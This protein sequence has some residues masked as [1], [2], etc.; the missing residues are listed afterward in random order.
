MAM[1]M[2]AVASS[3][4][5][6][7]A[8]FRDV[9]AADLKRFGAPEATARW[10]F[11]ERL[12]A[13]GERGE[14]GFSAYEG[15]DHLVKFFT[16]HRRA[17][18]PDVFGTAIA[19]LAAASAEADRRVFQRLGLNCDDL[20]VA[21]MARYNAQ[22]YA[23]QRAYAVPERQRIKVL[24][25]FGAGHGRMANLAF[26]TPRPG[27]RV[28]CYIAVDGIPSTYFVQSLYF[29]ALGLSV[30]D[31][32]DHADEG[33]G[34]E[35][36]AAAIQS[37][38][39]VHLPTWCLSLIPDGTADL[40]SC[41]QVLKE[42]P[43]ELLPWLLPHFARIAQPAGALYIRDH[44]QL[45]NPNHMPIDLLTQAAGF[46]LEFAPMIRDRAEIH[47]LPRIWRK[48]DPSLYV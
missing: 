37:H 7:N 12:A 25:D 14:M 24:L 18:F 48:V 42:L 1:F 35:D 47:G 15:P 21:K 41:V 5:E 33:V 29:Q 43:G 16:W 44:L 11:A 26:A 28:R 19:D 4:D 36:V 23:L 20:L 32:F 39:V 45:H 30:W 31:Y 13:R 38:D 17:A 6:L 10:L 40:I 9:A 8:R 34:P 3:P 2:E 27:E 46:A 22:D